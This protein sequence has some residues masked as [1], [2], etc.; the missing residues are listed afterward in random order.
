MTLG[1]VMI[2][3]IKD[4]LFERGMRKTP[5]LQASC[6]LPLYVSPECLSPFGC[7]FYNGAMFLQMAVSQ[8]P[9]V[10]YAVLPLKSVPLHQ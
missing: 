2:A 7:S 8:T 9:P 10:T 4:T 5:C 6:K 3:E 1:R